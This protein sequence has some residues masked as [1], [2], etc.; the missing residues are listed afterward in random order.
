MSDAEK[1]TFSTTVLSDSIRGAKSYVGGWRPI[2]TAPKDGTRMLLVTVLGDGTKRVDLGHWPIRPIHDQWSE[3]HQVVDP[4]W[5]E[6][7]HIPLWRTVE[8]WMPLPEIE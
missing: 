2:E 7:D 1:L 5:C 8:K 4:R 6:G 3:E